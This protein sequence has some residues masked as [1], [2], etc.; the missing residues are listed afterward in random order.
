M[1]IFLHSSKTYLINS[2]INVQSFTGLAL[3][4][5]EIIRSESLKTP[6]NFKRLKKS[7]V[8]RVNGNSAES[9][10]CMEIFW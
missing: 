10:I 5:P 4:V 3:M 7:G 6:R 9:D 2:T 1:K 8:N